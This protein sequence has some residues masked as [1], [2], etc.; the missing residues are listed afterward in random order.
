TA[1]PGSR[2]AATPSPIASVIAFAARCRAMGPPCGSPPV[3][4]F[5]RPGTAAPRPY[6]GKGCAT[7]AETP[8]H[9]R[10]SDS[11]P[12]EGGFLPF[13]RGRKGRS[14]TGFGNRPALDVRFPL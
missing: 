1:G 9:A 2:I 14:L 3:G 8:D 7:D 13:P 12:A 6:K 5:D 11:E 10:P 4:S